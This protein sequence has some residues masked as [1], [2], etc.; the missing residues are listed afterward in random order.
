MKQ[1]FFQRKLI[2]CAAVAALG[3]SALG[4]KI[5]LAADAEKDSDI[6]VIM[7]K[8]FKSTKTKP[9][10]LKKAQDGTATKEELSS[11]LDYTK[12]L[13]KTKPP[14]GEQKDWD[15]RMSMLVK[16]SEALVAGDTSAVKDLKTAG[17]CKECHKLHQ[18][19]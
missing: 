16:A 6:T 1:T 9:S 3:F 7:K 14:K 19:D 10:I 18:P 4:V 17:N 2:L 13:Q 11:L 15:D 12:Q 5:A 8:A